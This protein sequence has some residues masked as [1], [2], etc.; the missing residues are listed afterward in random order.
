MQKNP[1]VALLLS[2]IPGA[3]HA[4]L[5]RPIRFLLY[6]GGFFGA[7]ALLLLLAV[8]NS[9]DGA[10]V[11]F[12][13]FVA[14]ASWGINLLDMIITLL[15]GGPKQSR[16][17]YEGGYPHTEQV[18]TLEQQREKSQTILMS[19]I[20]GIGHMSIGLMQRGIAFLVAFLGLFAIVVF[21]SMVTNTG[22]FLIFLIGLPI[23]WIYS[24]FDAIQ[25]LNRKHRGEILQ[26]RP[27][28]EEMEEYI[29]TGKKNKVLAATLSLFPGAGHLYLGLQKRGLQIMAGFLIAVYLMDSLRLTIF[30]FLMPLVWFFAF[31]DA[32]Q[33]M[34][35]YERNEMNDQAVVAQLA[36]YQRWIGIGLLV[37]GIYYLGDRVM[38][39]YIQ[40]TWPVIYKEY[41]NLKYNL[42]TAVVAF[43]MIAAGLRLV[44]GGGGGGKSPKP[45]QARALDTSHK[46]KRS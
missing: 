43:V 17:V 10:I 19:L 44:F 26:D 41:M 25:L 22:V 11:A 45:P 39:S 13:L 2:C 7:L 27:F 28:F 36:P 30:F 15:S 35:R 33:Q 14:A 37:L 8:S 46:E 29:G 4:Y 16:T 6:A 38:G 1:V 23:I 24:M 21:V 32:L 42:P 9:A 5:G 20:P 34:S 31:F 18:I 40:E 3:G 12:L